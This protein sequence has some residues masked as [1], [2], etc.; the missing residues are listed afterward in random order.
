MLEFQVVAPD[1]HITG[2]NRD[3]CRFRPWCTLG[4]KR[5]KLENAL[6]TGRAAARR[7]R[8]GLRRCSLPWLGRLPG[9]NRFLEIASEVRI[10]RDDEAFLLLPP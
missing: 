7:C 1:T 5:G 2:H 9:D 3:R 4:G 8:I 10:S 6:L